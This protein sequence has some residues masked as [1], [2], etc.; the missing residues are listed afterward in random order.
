MFIKFRIAMM[1]NFFPVFGTSRFT[2]NTWNLQDGQKALK[3]AEEF[4]RGQETI[5]EQIF[6]YV[7]IKRMLF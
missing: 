2:S 7:S 5:L 6:M 3:R 1:I 4:S